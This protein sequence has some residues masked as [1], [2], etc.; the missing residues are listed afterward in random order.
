[1]LHVVPHHH[2]SFSANPTDR[3]IAAVELAPVLTPALPLNEASPQPVL[4]DIYVHS[5]VSPPDVGSPLVRSSAEACTYI[6]SLSLFCLLLW[7]PHKRN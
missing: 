3:V 2:E 6:L 5:L 1:M 7:H 4:C